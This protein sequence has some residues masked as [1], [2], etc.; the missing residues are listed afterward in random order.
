MQFQMVMAMMLYFYKKMPQ[1]IV[2]FTNESKFFTLV[3]CE[4]DTFYLDKVVFVSC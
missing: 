2:I 4:Y 3:V 1:K